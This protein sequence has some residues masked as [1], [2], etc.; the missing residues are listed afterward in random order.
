MKS[1][2]DHFEP[3]DKR[4]LSELTPRSKQNET[5]CLEMNEKTQ[6]ISIESGLYSLILRSKLESARIFKAMGNQRGIASH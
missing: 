3:E 4:R 1:I 6:F 2:R 5:L